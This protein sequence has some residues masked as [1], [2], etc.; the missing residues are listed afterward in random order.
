MPMSSI[1]STPLGEILIEA[2]GAALTAVRFLRPVT[3][4]RVTAVDHAP[5]VADPRAGVP[6]RDGAV[7]DSATEAILVAAREQLA[8]YVAGSRRHVDLPVRASGTPFQQA[9][10]S[11]LSLIPYGSTWTYRRLATS[12]GR[13]TATRAVGAACGRNPVAIVVPCHRVV[14]TDGTLT[15]YAG[16]T[17]IKA[18]LLDLETRTL[19]RDGGPARSSLVR[20]A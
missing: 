10:W 4:P 7:P 11:A 12:L 8:A 17:A 15:G 20:L 6:G 1:L 9:V 19:A 2:D 13:P 3:D 14:G 18:A 16:G 5:S